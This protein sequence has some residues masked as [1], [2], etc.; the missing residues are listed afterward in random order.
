MYD[1]TQRAGVYGVYVVAF[2]VVFLLMCAPSKEEKLAAALREVER[3]D[4]MRKKTW[5]IVAEQELN[6]IREGRESKVSCFT[7][8]M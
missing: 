7:G 8:E 6:F 3:L 4:E 5:E 2:M 1:V